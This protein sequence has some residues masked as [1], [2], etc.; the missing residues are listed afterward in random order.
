MKIGRTYVGK[1][2]RVGK[3]LIIYLEGGTRVFVGCK[4]C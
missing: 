4:I 3:W 2:A 1:I